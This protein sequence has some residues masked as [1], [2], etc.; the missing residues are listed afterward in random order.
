[1]V[2]MEMTDEYDG[3]YP[4]PTSDTCRDLS[5]SSQMIEPLTEKRIGHHGFSFVLEE[6]RGMPNPFQR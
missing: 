1:M 5:V 4:V 2:L 3:R 6:D